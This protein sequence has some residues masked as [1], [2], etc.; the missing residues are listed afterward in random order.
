MENTNIEEYYKCHHSD[1]D[2]CICFDSADS[3]YFNCKYCTAT[4]HEYCIAQT[5]LE[6]EYYTGCPVCRLDLPEM[7]AVTNVKN[8]YSSCNW[9]LELPVST[10]MCR[11]LISFIISRCS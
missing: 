4:F 6:N 3:D 1:S 5:M 7:N 2:C 9:V 11:T 10:Y 8:M